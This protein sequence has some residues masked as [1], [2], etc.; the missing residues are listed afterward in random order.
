MGTR[1]EQV[2]VSPTPSRGPHTQWT[3][4]HFR[5]RSL[6]GPAVVPGPLGV[7]R[8]SIWSP[9]TQACLCLTPQS[10]CD[11]LSE[12]DQR[13][14]HR[15]GTTLCQAL[16]WA[17]DSHDLSGFSVGGR[18]AEPPWLT[19]FTLKLRVGSD[20]P[21]TTQPGYIRSSF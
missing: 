8:G 6:M 5:S 13:S 19:S 12:G 2:T 10:R 15:L 21:K 20:L 11:L 18:R 1:D 16:C 9:D 4:T 7:G 3:P 17:F 14:I